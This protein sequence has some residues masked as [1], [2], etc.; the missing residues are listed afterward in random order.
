MSVLEKGKTIIKRIGLFL[1]SFLLT[2]SF[3]S[4][5]VFADPQPTT[6]NTTTETTQP[7]SPDTTTQP[8][9]LNTTT[10]TTSNTASTNACYDESGSLGW[11][12]CPA[13][14]FLSKVIDGLYSVIEGFLVIS[15][16]TSDTTSPYHQVWA[17]FRDATNIIFG[18]FF[19]IIIYSQLTGIGISNYGIKRLLPK[20]VVSAIL[21]NLSY[22]ICALLVDLSNIF[23]VSLRGIFADVEAQVTATGL[24]AS[25]GGS[26]EINYTTM[27]SLLTGTLLIGGVSIGAAGGLGYL[28]FAF[29]SVV[30]GGVV[31]LVAA[32]L[33]VAARQAL[34]YLLIMISPL[35]FVCM[36]LPNTETWFTKWKKTLTSMLIFY[37]M[38]AA[39]FGACSL[40]GWV[41]IA[42]ANE[43]VFLILGMAVK[44]IPLITSW[45]LLRMSGTIPGQVN[46]IFRNLTRGPVTAASR[47]AQNEALA[48]RAKY[49]GGTAGATQYSRRLGQYLENRRF[50]QAAD[51]AQ[52]LEASKIRGAAFTANIR[53]RRGNITRRGEEIARLKLGNLEHQNTI[54]QSANIYERGLSYYSKN[55]KQRARL[56]ALDHSTMEAA[57]QLYYTTSRGEKIRFDNAES[58]TN[59]IDAAFSAHTQRAL[60]GRPVNAADLAR[61]NRIV[62]AVEGDVLNSHLVAA[63]AATDYAN[64]S[65]IL[66]KKFAPYF[67]S[68]PATQELYD[69]ITELTSR[70]DINQN[71]DQILAGLTAIE[72]RGDTDLVK[73][74]IDRMVESGQIKLGTHASQALANFCMFT[75]KDSDIMLRRYGKYINLETA[76]VFNE[77][78]SRGK[79]KNATLTFAELITGNYDEYDDSGNLVVGSGK[80]KLSLAQLLEGTSLD[81]V[82]RTAFDNLAA[83]V[84]KAY[85]R[86]VPASATTPA[87]DELD[88]E[89]YEKKLFE[90]ENALAPA[91][92]SAMLKY[93]SGSEQIVNGSSF[94][95][96]LKKKG[97]TWVKRWEDP[98]DPFFGLDE[99]VFI[100]RTERYLKAQT[101]QQILSLRTDVFNPIVEVL[102]DKYIAQMQNGEHPESNIPNAM[103]EKPPTE[104]PDW[105]SLPDSSLTDD[106]KKQK[107]SLRNSF[108]K[109][110]FMSLLEQ[111]DAL[112]PIITSRRSGAA[113]AAKRVVRDFLGLTDNDFVE[114]YRD[115][116]NEERRRHREERRRRRE[117]REPEREEP[118]SETGDSSFAPLYTP[119]EREQFKDEFT[120]HYY[121]DPENEDFY[122]DIYND[123][124]GANLDIIAQ[125]FREFREHNPSASNSDLLNYLLSLFDDDSNF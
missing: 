24:L 88:R 25:A 46:S 41:I 26:L 37:P 102:A 119:A 65:A 22:I 11:L 50:R 64:Q 125:L 93:P 114:D 61:Y 3:Y 90:I 66:N 9:T 59:R 105:F 33:T 118:T 79:R 86:H 74:Q 122:D 73:A 44:V 91:F 97:N 116:M 63:N 120:N 27:V 20:I 68:I 49:L 108:A 54:Q 101:P 56:G 100:G 58:R 110:A 107:K 121:D 123:L 32:F 15:P 45:S 14:G 75:V 70:H 39:L 12:V 99:N 40:V 60:Y 111:N 81:G 80:S 84:R 98:S 29:I 18:I 67:N 6:P 38:F 48:R 7:S 13:T 76:R 36:L 43:P 117:G 115:Q 77:G 92:I 62:N 1:A 10:E 113:N 52:Y 47:A 83:S 5:P 23:G 55:E 87:H 30:L 104:L 106:Q 103:G 69:R 78:Q 21:I 96:G 28:L 8:T 42:S 95:T 94:L 124:L 109:A 112:E 53:N 82:E 89:A 19:L 35:A 72:M 34:V 71:I 57:D 51:N 85:T 4:T 31:A 17:I 2:L 16:L